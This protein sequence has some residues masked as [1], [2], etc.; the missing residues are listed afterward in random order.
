LDSNEVENEFRDL[1]G[2]QKGVQKI[3][4]TEIA[5]D[6]LLLFRDKLK[7]TGITSGVIKD[8]GTQFLG[9]PIS[10]FFSHVQDTVSSIAEKQ[11]KKLK[12]LQFL[13]SNIRIAPEPYQELFSS[14]IH[15]IRNSVDHGIEMPE[16]RVKVGKPAEGTLSFR[17]S[18]LESNGHWL[19]IQL[20]DDGGG[21]DAAKLRKK[22]VEKGFPKAEGES[23]QTVIQHVFD[24]GLSTK[25]EVTELSGRGVGMDAIL[26]ASRNLGGT[27]KVY[28]KRGMGT[29][30]SVI[31]P[32]IEPSEIRLNVRKRSKQEGNPPLAA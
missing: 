27:A 4:Y 20:A 25:E 3:R 26:T 1:I 24:A 12:P 23:D 17:F 29:V 15:A 31:V 32:Y 14:F 19:K 11:G 16:E 18:I 13:S 21:I 6:Q 9:E 7:S 10:R 8:F 5:V 28:T 2:S 22:L 30:L